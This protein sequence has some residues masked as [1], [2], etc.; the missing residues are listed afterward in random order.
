M[1]CGDPV[2][3]LSLINQVFLS[4]SP[5]INL[6]FGST[7]FVVCSSGYKFNAEI[8]QY[9]ISCTPNGKWTESLP[10]F[11]KIFDSSKFLRQFY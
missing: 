4:G 7:Q 2:S 8:Q 11:G 3:N 6:D 5:Q 1:N 9:N 10:C